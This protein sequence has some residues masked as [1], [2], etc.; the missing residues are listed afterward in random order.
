MVP[1]CRP[2]FRGSLPDPG[3]NEG[4][5][6]MRR[7]LRQVSQTIKKGGQSGRHRVKPAGE[8]LSCNDQ[9]RCSMYRPSLPT[10]ATAVDEAGVYQQPGICGDRRRTEDAQP[11]TPAQTAAGDEQPI[12]CLS[13]T[14][15][16]LVHTAAFSPRI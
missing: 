6:R 16:D 12:N 15:T 9:R 13:R 14:E 2:L 8:R 5:E 3:Q 7:E 10:G 4:L 1:P 11:A